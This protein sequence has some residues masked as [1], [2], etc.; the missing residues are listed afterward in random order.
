MNPD[1][2]ETEAF[3][4]RTARRVLR[5]HPAG[6]LMKP[7]RCSRLD[8]RGEDRA[9]SAAPTMIALYINREFTDAAVAGT[10]AVGE[11]RRKSDRAC[12]RAL[13]D[14]HEM[15]SGKPPNDVCSRARRGLEGGD[16]VGD[17]LV[18]NRR[19]RRRI[20]G[21][22]RPCPPFHQSAIE[23]QAVRACSYQLRVR[24]TIRTTESMTGTSTS[25]PTTV[26]SAA[27]D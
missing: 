19:D 17:A 13:G 2:L 26:A 22:S 5:K 7:G 12:S 11:R 27:P 23:S 24:K 3:Q 6:K 9:P 15:V 1:F 20:G 16:A 18:I 25:T 8:Q 4:K 10:A 14:H 21:R